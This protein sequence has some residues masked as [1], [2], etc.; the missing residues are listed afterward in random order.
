MRQQIRQCGHEVARSCVRA[1]HSFQ[2]QGCLI[3]KRIRVDA[4]AGDRKVRSPG[5]H[6]ELHTRGGWRDPEQR[7]D[8]VLRREQSLVGDPRARLCEGEACPYEDVRW[9]RVSKRHVHEQ[10]VE[11][12]L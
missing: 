6:V 4:R 8:V 7:G 5:H 3:L 10:V 9:L 11:A 2:R 12:C 1:T